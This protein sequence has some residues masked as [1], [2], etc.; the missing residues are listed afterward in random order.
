MI[1]NSLPEPLD[2]FHDDADRRLGLINH[3]A[4]AALVCKKLLAVSR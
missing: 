1:G 3:D 4:V 2:H